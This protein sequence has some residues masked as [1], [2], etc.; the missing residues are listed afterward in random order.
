VFDP[1]PRTEVQRIDDDNSAWQSRVARRRAVRRTRRGVI[2]GSVTVL[3]AAAVGL[4]LAGVL[5]TAH[6]PARTVADPDSS[7]AWVSPGPSTS[8]GAVAQLSD[9]SPSAS[10]S[11][12]PASPSPTTAAP[13]AARTTAKPLSGNSSYEAQ[14]VTLVNQERAKAGCPALTVDSRLTAAARGHSQDMAQRNYF[15]H[16]TPEGVTP[17]TRITN[18]GYH[19]STAAENIAEGQTTPASVMDAWMN[20]PGHRANIL[21]CA[22]RNI[23]VGLAYNAKHTPYWTQDFGTP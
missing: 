5:G 1:D 13:T 2:Y 8:N 22:L 18:A 7:A 10:P 19:F 17:W 4:L 21:N 23:G 20:S 11:A 9:I 6:Q 14:V 12:P 15:D 16:N 3:A